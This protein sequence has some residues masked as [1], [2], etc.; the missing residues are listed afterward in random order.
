MGKA[1]TISM[2]AG[3]TLDPTVCSVPGVEILVGELIP[4]G[5]KARHD[6]LHVAKA[7]PLVEVVLPMLQ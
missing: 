6:C 2:T 1:D 4:A 3:G 5:A 7:R